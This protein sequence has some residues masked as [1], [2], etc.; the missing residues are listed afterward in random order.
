MARG[1]LVAL[2]NPENNLPTSEAH[3][4][5]DTPFAVEA[6]NVAIS[7]VNASNINLSEPEKKLL[8]WHH[9]LGH[10]NFRKIQYLMR[11]GILSKSEASRRLH[12]SSCKIL[13]PPKCAACQYGK[14]HQ[15]PVPGKTASVVKHRVGVLRN[16]NLLPGQQISYILNSSRHV[17]QTSISRRLHF[18]LLAEWAGKLY[19]D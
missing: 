13:T 8:C 9:R 14:Q 5:K 1:K 3:S 10:M 2:I 12:T 18:M 11:T 16:G 6:L 17:Y 4:F 15:R 19:R 7:T